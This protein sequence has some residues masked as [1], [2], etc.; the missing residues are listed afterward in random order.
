MNLKEFCER[1]G[2]EN[3]E[4]F[5]KLICEVDLSRSMNWRRFKVWQYSDGTKK[6]LLEVIKLNKRDAIKKRN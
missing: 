3:E 2:F 4:E 1:N 5:H 6:S